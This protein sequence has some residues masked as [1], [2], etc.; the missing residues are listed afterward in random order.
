MNQQ[1]LQKLTLEFKKTTSIEGCTKVCL[2]KETLIGAIEKAVLSEN[3]KNKVDGHQRRIGREKLK[4]YLEKLIREKSEDIEGCK[5]F[6]FLYKTIESCRMKGIGELTTYDIAVRIASYLKEKMYYPDSILPDK[7]YLHRGAK[8]G[9][10]ILL[11]S[12]CKLKRKMPRTAF[13]PPL[14]DS[15]LTCDQI[16]SFLCIYK[17]R[18]KK[19]VE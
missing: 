6:D 19:Y 3:N 5:E 14:R 13:P 10:R 15:N 1:E 2:S 4:H 17:S 12:K 9:A 16:E 7:V 8:E 11:G 18:L